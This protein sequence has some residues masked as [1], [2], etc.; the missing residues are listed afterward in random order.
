MYI[1]YLLLLLFGLGSKVA[2]TLVKFLKPSLATITLALEDTK[3]DCSNKY[4][5]S[6]FTHVG[7][8]TRFKGLAR[9]RNTK[10]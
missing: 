1:T 9:A 10:K 7:Q 2:F 8:F 3:Y 5:S 4:L 6:D